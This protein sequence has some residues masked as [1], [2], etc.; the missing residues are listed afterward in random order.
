[1]SILMIGSGQTRWFCVRGHAARKW[2]LVDGETRNWTPDKN[3]C[4]VAR[5]GMIGSV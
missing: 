1:M 5:M 2:I 4:T 3:G